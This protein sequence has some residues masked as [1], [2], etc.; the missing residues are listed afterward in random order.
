MNRTLLLLSSLLF[1]ANA[2]KLN[3]GKKALRT[4]TSS[5]ALNDE[6]PI[7]GAEEQER[8]D[9]VE[10]TTPA[11]MTQRGNGMDKTFFCCAAKADGE[12]GWLETSA[13]VVTSELGAIAALKTAG[14]DAKYLMVTHQVS[15]GG[16]WVA[17]TNLKD[18]AGAPK[19]SV[20]GY[21]VKRSDFLV[22]FKPKMQTF[23]CHKKITKAAKNVVNKATTTTDLNYIKS[24]MAAICG[25]VGEVTLFVE[26][27][28]NVLL[29]DVAPNSSGQTCTDGVTQINSGIDKCL[30]AF[31]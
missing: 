11:E 2:R 5:V 21:W 13:E 6:V 29:S 10:A 1:F 15:E 24:K 22:D 7:S 12:Y 3:E 16:E 8:V 20:S 25:V 27:G 28:G 26:P 4:L 9:N 23:Q 31:A 17:P 30:P 18:K 19:P 14:I